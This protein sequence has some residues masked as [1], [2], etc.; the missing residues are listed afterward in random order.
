MCAEA[1]DDSLSDWSSSPVAGGRRGVAVCSSTWKIVDVV[2]GDESTYAACQSASVHRPQ[3]D[4][5][6]YSSS[7][8]LAVYFNGPMTSTTTTTTAASTAHSDHHQHEHD[9]RVQD[10]PLQLLHF[11]GLLKLR[12]YIRLQHY[13]RHIN[14]RLLHNELVKYRLQLTT[15][16]TVD[17]ASVTSHNQL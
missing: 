7:N 1:G 16:S 9:N 11:T 8:R 6:Y 4:R 17:C 5:T 2:S 3:P 10:A 14:W 15:W 12:A 13:Y